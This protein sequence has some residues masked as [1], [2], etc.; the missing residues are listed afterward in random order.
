MNAVEDTVFSFLRGR[1][2]E[3]VNYLNCTILKPN[4]DIIE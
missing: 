1:E 2:G 3:N 4:K